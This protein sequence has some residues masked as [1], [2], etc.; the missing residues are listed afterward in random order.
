[1]TSADDDLRRLLARELH[2]EAAR[3]APAEDG[4]RRIHGRLRSRP[5]FPLWGGLRVDAERY[6]YRV[7]YVAAEALAWLFSLARRGWQVPSG[8]FKTTPATQATA[9][10]ATRA[11]HTA[12][13]VSAGTRRFGAGAFSGFRVT[14][15]WVGTIGLRLVVTVAAVCLFAGTALAVPGV[16]H[17]IGS[18]ASSSSGGPGSGGGTGGTGGTG[19]GTGPAGPRRD[20]RDRRD[21]RQRQRPADPR[22]RAADPR[23]RSGHQPRFEEQRERPG[24]QPVAERQLD[25]LAGRQDP[26]QA[27]HDPEPVTRHAVGSGGCADD[28]IVADANADPGVQQHADHGADDT[29]TRPAA[30]PEAHRQLEV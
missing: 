27:S 11:A 4:L 23:Y 12:D 8:R 18:L 13:G 1:M 22:C 30:P 29:D 21:R 15:Q 2:A 7:R 16:R 6:G 9:A 19:G 26:D 20:G 17:V 24:D 5:S 10:P 28:A 14:Y 25:L 3:F